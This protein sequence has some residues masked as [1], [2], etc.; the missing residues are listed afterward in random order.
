MIFRE[1]TRQEASEARDGTRKTKE[2]GGRGQMGGEQTGGKGIER[3]EWP[4]GREG[5]KRR[6]RG[7]LSENAYEYF[8][9]S[10]EG[11]LLHLSQIYR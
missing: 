3:R 4:D 8:K 6:T 2:E 5:H 9:F 1:E 10:S 7:C 11:V